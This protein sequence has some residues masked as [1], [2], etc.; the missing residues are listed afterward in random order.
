MRSKSRLATLVAAMVVLASP[1]HAERP[2]NV[3]VLSTERPRS[4][5]GRVVGEASRGFRFVSSSTGESFDL[6]EIDEIHLDAS[7]QVNLPRVSPITV[8]LGPIGRVSGRLLSITGEEVVLANSVEAPPI[9]FRRSGVRGIWQRT[10]EAEVHADDFEGARLDPAIWTSAGNPSL[11]GAA[12]GDGTRTMRIP[13]GGSSTA[14]RLVE[15]IDAGRMVIDYLED[16]EMVNGQSRFIELTFL[17]PGGHQPIRILLGWDEGTLGVRTTG[18]GPILAVQPLERR[19]GWHRLEVAFDADRTDITVDEIELAHGGAPVGPLTEIRFANQATDNELVA[20]FDDFSLVRYASTIA[21]VESEPLQDELRLVSGDQLFGTVITADATTVDLDQQGSR[22]SLSWID[23]AGIRL[24]R[25]TDCSELIS[26]LWV[27]LLWRMSP[28]DRARQADQLEGALQ[29]I[30]DESITILVPFSGTVEIPINQ[31]ASIEVL[32]NASRMVIDSN[33]RHLGNRM[34]N[35]LEPPQPEGSQLELKFPVADPTGATTKLLFDVVQVI[36]IEGDAG[37]SKLVRDGWLRTHVE[38]NGK[39]IGDLNSQVRSR[40]PTSIRIALAIPE[41]VLTNGV[42]TLSLIQDGTAD[43]PELV[44]NLG[45]SGVILENP[46]P[47][48]PVEP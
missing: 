24:R 48:G 38:L 40:N 34:V 8:D 25:A 12:G 16:G 9:S 35:D 28:K 10:G 33:S 21:G 23:L 22:V 5:A 27:R 46:L 45:L 20:Q 31:L 43:D 37:Y 19:A 32:E 44:D 30:D 18:P 36:G 29:K 3:T 11:D 7:G 14:V 1:V 4:E 15:P 6:S 17:G 47:R 13:G 39:R 41:G 2:L 42:N 26:G